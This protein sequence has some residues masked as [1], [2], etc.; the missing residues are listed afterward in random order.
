M[1]WLKRVLGN[2]ASMANSSK[3]FSTSDQP[4]APAALLVMNLRPP[5]ARAA[6]DL[7]RSTLSKALL[8]VMRLSSRDTCLRRPENDEGLISRRLAR[9]AVSESPPRMFWT[10]TASSR[11]SSV[12]STISSSSLNLAL[13]FLLPFLL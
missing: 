4:S 5:R 6:P 7:L 8:E 12:I 3:R 9:K 10:E 13:L 1:H 11:T 2:F